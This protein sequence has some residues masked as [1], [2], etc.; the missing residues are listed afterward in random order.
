M[1]APAVASVDALGAPVE[2]AEDV[3]ELDEVVASFFLS[4]SLASFVALAFESCVARALSSFVAPPPC[5]VLVVGVPEGEVRAPLVEPG[6]AAAEPDDR[7]PDVGA[8]PGAALDVAPA[9]GRALVVR[10]AVAV[11]VGLGRLVVVGAAG[12]GGAMLGDCPDP[13]RNPTTEPGAA[14]RDHAPFDA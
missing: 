1:E 4:L 5:V 10:V 14:A 11:G 9:P 6:A 13:R 8:A 12:F 3:V 7:A 2:V